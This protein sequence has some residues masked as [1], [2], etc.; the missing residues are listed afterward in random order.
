MTGPIEHTYAGRQVIHTE[1]ADR[2]YRDHHDAA[3]EALAV[4]TPPNANRALVITGI[5]VGHAHATSCAGVATIEEAG[6]VVFPFPIRPCGAM[7]IE[8]VHGI[9]MECGATAGVRVTMAG[10]TCYA[11]IKCR[12]E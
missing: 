4:V 3:D 8:F 1:D 5:I 6:N 11:N 9:R 10:V 2:S 7:A 12:L